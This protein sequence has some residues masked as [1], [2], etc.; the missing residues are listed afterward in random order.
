M[1][2]D[3]S[4]SMLSTISSISPQKVTCEIETAGQKGGLSFHLFQQKIEYS[5]QTIKYFWIHYLSL[6]FSKTRI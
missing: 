6:L 1:I 5:Y 3:T 4:S 2:S